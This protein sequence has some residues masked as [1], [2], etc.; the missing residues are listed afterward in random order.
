MRIYI[1]MLLNLRVDFV[2][3]QNTCC[4]IYMS[5]MQMKLRLKRNINVNVN[6]PCVSLTTIHAY[7][8]TSHPLH[9][10]RQSYSVH[11]SWNSL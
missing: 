3:R 7:V 10:T 1:E 6:V 5:I 8:H 11:L 4:Y 2:L 9:I